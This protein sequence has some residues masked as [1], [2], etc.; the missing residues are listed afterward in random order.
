VPLTLIYARALVND[1]I[2]GGKRDHK[3]ISVATNDPEYT[4]TRGCE[5]PASAAM[6]R[7][8][9]STTSNWKASCGSR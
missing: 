2:D 1:M 8:F 7:R 6:L 9:F 4:P 5:M 3:V